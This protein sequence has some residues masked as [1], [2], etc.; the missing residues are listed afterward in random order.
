MRHFDLTYFALSALVTL[1]SITLHEFGHAIAADKLGDDT[2]RREGRITLNPGAH[3][4][5]LGLL[6]ILMTS[7]TGFGLGW[8]KPV[9]VNLRNF[10]NERKADLIVT[11]M[12]PAMNLLL[13]LVF[14]LLLRVLFAT[15]K[16]YALPDL[17]YQLFFIFVMRNLGLM[18]FNLL[19]I[20]PLDG[21]HIM[22]RLLPPSQGQ[23][24]Y[25]W[26]QQYGP[27]VLLGLV[28]MGGSLISQMISPAMMSVAK[29]IVGFPEGTFGY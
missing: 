11:I 16:V 26:M 9:M 2:P 7:F 1:L 21:S 5:P 12:G 15:G 22:H 10:R 25:L 19:P 24:Y 27:F 3:F 6:M 17:A 28:F 18:F 8:G 29:L 20:F 4:D 14:G 23:T 13:A